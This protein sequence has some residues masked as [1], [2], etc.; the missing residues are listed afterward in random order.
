MEAKHAL[1]VAEKGPYRDRLLRLIEKSV[2]FSSFN[3]FNTI[4][5]GETLTIW[6]S[7]SVAPNR[8]DFEPIAGFF[9]IWH[10]HQRGSHCGVHEFYW[11]KKKE[12]GVI[13]RK[14]EFVF[15]LLMFTILCLINV[16]L[17]IKGLAMHEL[18]SLKYL[19][20]SKQSLTVNANWLLM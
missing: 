19:S 1:E 14:K 6:I 10:E 7:A 8:K 9:G 11:C 16:I 4:K 15:L 20:R 17:D 2:P 12:Q 18:H 5:P 3:D 13:I